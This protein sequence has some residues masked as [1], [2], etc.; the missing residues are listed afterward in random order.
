MDEKL[1]H[2]CLLDLCKL[3]AMK[4]EKRK[5]SSLTRID[6]FELVMS[7]SYSEMLVNGFCEI[8]IPKEIWKSKAAISKAVSTILTNFSSFQGKILPKLKTNILVMDGGNGKF[9]IQLEEAKK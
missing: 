6:E 7:R 4:G 2:S 3:I 1:K 9:R 8:T 5:N